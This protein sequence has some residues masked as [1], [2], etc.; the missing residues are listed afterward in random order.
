MTFIIICIFLLILVSAFF[1]GSETALTAA[2]RPLMHQR[3]R[4]GDTRARL[5][6][7]MYDDKERLIGTI[8]L[9]NNLVNILASSLATSVLITLFG[10]AGIAYATLG[11][12]VLV[13]IFAEV[14]PKTYAFQ[15]ADTMAL[16]IAPA[17]G[18]L[19]FLLT[20]VTKLMQLLVS[21]SLRLFGVRDDSSDALTTNL[22]ALRG[23]IEMHEGT[24]SFN[25]HERAMLRSVL[26]LNEVVVSEIMTHRKSMITF[27]VDTPVKE[28]VDQVVDSPYSRIPL[29]REEPDKIVGILHAKA[30]LRAVRDQG[31]GLEDLD[32]LSLMGTPWFVP[33]TTKL[34]DQLQAFRQRREHFAIVIDEYGTILG[35]VTLEDILE[36]IV[37]DIS[38][39]HDVPVEGVRPK[40]D[41][42]FVVDGTVTIRDLN[43]QFEWDLPDD[44]AATIA[45]LILREARRIP[46]A[47]QIFRFHGLQIEVLHRK[48]NQIT[49]VLLTPVD[50]ADSTEQEGEPA[51]TAP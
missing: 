20:P 49:S 6:T 10:D 5:V 9:G 14:L 33:D 12:T 40:K 46:K 31:K 17:I 32:V 51:D 27:N 3:E 34:L 24:E 7:R 13:L 8:L 28:L 16:K 2:S 15:N 21:L 48:R 11:M 45:G 47:G 22:E 18:F 25:Q 29:W 23:A 39:E 1:S 44:E 4:G 26:D 19:M 41:G 50:A 36:E 35:V 38:D 37:G 30:L 43:R 42:S